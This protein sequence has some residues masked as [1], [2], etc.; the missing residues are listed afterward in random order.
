MI[1]TVNS[2][3]N[4]PEASASARNDRDNLQCLLRNRKKHIKSKKRKKWRNDFTY[5]L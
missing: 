2:S 3:Q 4:F 5:M 1:Y